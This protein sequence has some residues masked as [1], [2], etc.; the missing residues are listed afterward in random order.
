MIRCLIFQFSRQGLP[1][2][3]LFHPGRAR[4]HMPQGLNGKPR[5]DHAALLWGLLCIPHIQDTGY[6]VKG[7]LSF[8]FIP[9]CL[10]LF[11]P[12]P[13]EK[14]HQSGVDKCCTDRPQ[15]TEQGPVRHSPCPA[16]P[17]RPI[18]LFHRND[19]ATS[20]KS[21]RNRLPCHVAVSEVASD[22]RVHFRSRSHTGPAPCRRHL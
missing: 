13:D 14:G 1:D 9:V 5:S 10:V 18:G 8:P 2:C 20:R 11:L 17:C 3:P 16:F 12:D 15:T 6:R 7:T 4:P 21:G 22:A 19:A